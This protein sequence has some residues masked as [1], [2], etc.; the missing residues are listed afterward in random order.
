[1]HRE[2]DEEEKRYQ[3]HIV[4]DLHDAVPASD[5][6]KVH[7]RAKQLEKAGGVYERRQFETV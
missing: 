2:E 4:P 1:M 6:E 7:D 5:S 3:V